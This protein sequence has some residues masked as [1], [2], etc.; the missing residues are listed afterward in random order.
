MRLVAKLW[1]TF[2]HMPSVVPKYRSGDLALLKY[3][4]APL[5]FRQK[6]QELA[7]VLKDYTLDGN[8]VLFI[9]RPHFH[10]LKADASGHLWNDLVRM[11]PCPHQPNAE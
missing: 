8:R 3:S 7:G 2:V 1:L 9:F 6:L 4:E 11:A 10:H 5:S